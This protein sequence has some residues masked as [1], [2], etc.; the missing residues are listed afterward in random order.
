MQQQE[1]LCGGHYLS[2]DDPVRVFAAG[3]DTNALAIEVVWRSGA[4]SVVPKAKANRIYEIDEAAAEAGAVSPASAPRPQPLFRDVSQLLGHTHHEQLFSD[5]ARQP[6]LAKQF[7]QLGPG[8][9]WFDLDSD[10]HDELVLGSGKGGTLAVYRRN[11]SGGFAEVKA[12][13]L[14]LAP[15]D[16]CG[17]AAWVTSDGRRAV[18]AA[19]ANYESE[20]PGAHAVLRCSLSDPSGKLELA[21][22]KDVP[23]REASPGPIA[24]ADIDGDGDLDLF[25]GGR[26]TRGAYPQATT[27]K[28][29]RQEGGRLVPDSA[30]NNRL[31]GLGLVSGA[32]WTDLDADGFPEL[33]LASEWG[34]LKVFKNERGRLQD[35][36]DGL[37][38]AGYRLVERC[39]H[40]GSGRRR[41]A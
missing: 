32:V 41:A 27:S 31:E 40:R 39:D 1:I 35:A 22:L 9:A 34:P 7:S 29:F 25:W 17:L 10:G 8:A 20:T 18:L 15:D 11:A 36:T 30:N 6:L 19:L 5:Y 33:V 28:I 16:L 3:S 24:V 38:L 4:K 13:N 12:G 26:L 23:A 37:G 21:A 2:G 14:W